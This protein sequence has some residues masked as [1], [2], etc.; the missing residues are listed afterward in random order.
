M[1]GSSREGKAKLRRRSCQ[2]G[3]KNKIWP[4]LTDWAYGCS[5]SQG[6]FPVERRHGS[7]GGFCHRKGRT[8]G[9][10][11]V[12]LLVGGS[13]YFTP[14]FPGRPHDGLGSCSTYLLNLQIKVEVS[15]DCLIP[16]GLFWSDQGYNTQVEVFEPN[17]K[18]I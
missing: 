7:G 8:K 10:H 2:A 11:R 12:V 17:A 13:L 14:K 5:F 9:I 4:V 3:A 16:S 15:N 6:L 1:L 18:L